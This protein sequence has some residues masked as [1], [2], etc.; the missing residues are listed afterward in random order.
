MLDDFDV[1]DRRERLD[2]PIEVAF[3]H[4]GAADVHLLVPAVLE[5]EDARVFQEAADDRAHADV[6]AD[7]GDAGTQAAD[8][9][10]DHVDLHARL[11][12]AVEHT[13]HLVVGDRVYLED[14][15]RRAARFRMLGFAVDQ[16]AETR[17]QIH[18]R[19]EHA[20]VFL[21]T[22]IAGQVVEDIGYVGAE[23]AV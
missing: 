12:G 11:R 16:L 15:P 23:H 20:A 18:R 9:A 5:P 8:A 7:A 6:I 17:A 3:H 2:A 4:V 14:D 21:L 22:R 19:D 1:A 10:D 13:N